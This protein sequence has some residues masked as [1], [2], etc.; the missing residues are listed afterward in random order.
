MYACM[1]TPT[2]KPAQFVLLDC[3][4]CHPA[5]SQ[6][7]FH[8]KR[9]AV[10]MGADV[11][12]IAMGLASHILPAPW[13][14]ECTRHAAAS[15]NPLH[16]SKHNPSRGS[17]AAASLS[18]CTKQGGLRALPAWMPGRYWACECA[19]TRQRSLFGSK[20]CIT[21]VP[22]LQH[23]VAGWWRGWRLDDGAGACVRLRV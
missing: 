17:G 7:D 8:W 10:A 22:A 11:L 3:C 21:S 19:L 16:P 5:L 18:A 9:T 14:C 15:L 6:S 13:H 1:S 4:H 2:S 12:M 23:R 20:Y